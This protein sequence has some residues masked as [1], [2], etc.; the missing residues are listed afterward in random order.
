MRTRAAA[1]ALAALALPLGFLIPTTT[2]AASPLPDPQDPATV[3][4]LFVDAWP[5]SDAAKRGKAA[6]EANCIGCHGPEGLG[7]GGAAAWLDPKPRNFQKGY[8][9]F[10]TTASGQ[11]PTED[12]LFR[13]ITK[14]L[15][16]SSMPGFPLVAEG[17]RRDLV[18]YVLHLAAFG[19]GQAHARYLMDEEGASA[20]D[21]AGARLSEIAGR[22]HADQFDGR[23]RIP[24]GDAPA[25]TP[26]VLARGASIYK[27][28]CASC[29]GTTGRGDGGSSYTLR[30]WQ[31]AEIRPRDFT[32]GTFRSGNSARDLFIR[33][34]SGLNGTP[35][36]AAVS[37]PDADVWAVVLY[38]MSLKQPGTIPAT[39]RMGAEG[40]N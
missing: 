14:G 28:Q 25:A 31:E 40:G 19:K 23:K 12:D 38:V 13:T 27:Q 17:T 6:Y 37:E 36:P 33:M 15:P 18:A 2:P 20:K 11:L 21:V 24:V 10:R 1:L 39:R 30:D 26:D 34:R 35:M 22:V 5:A 7:D 4:P 29:H 8:F 16:G 32:S 9:K 3:G